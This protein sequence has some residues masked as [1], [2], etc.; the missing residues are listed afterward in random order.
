M[1][2]TLSI[3]AVIGS[4]FIIASYLRFKQLGEQFAS[5]LVLFLSISDLIRSI[6]KIWGSFLSDDSSLDAQCSISALMINFGGLTSF[7]F[8]GAIALVMFTAVNIKYAAFWK[9]KPEVL[10]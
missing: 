1:N 6:G 7:L 3:L 8:V 9:A 10:R 4:T 2:H 5:S